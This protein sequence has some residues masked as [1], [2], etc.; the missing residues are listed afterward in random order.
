MSE[1]TGSSPVA[2]VTGGAGFIGFHLCRALLGA[3]WH[4]RVLDNLSTG[5]FS[6]LEGLPLEFVEGDIRDQGAVRGALQGVNAVLHQAALVSVVESVKDPEAAHAINVE[7]TR[8]VFSEALAAGATRATFASSAAV[9]GDAAESP[10]HEGLPVVPLSPYGVGK[11][12]GE[13]IAAEMTAAGL[14][15][16]P[17]RYFNIYGPGQDPRGPYA[18][19]I[20]K[21]TAQLRAGARLTLFGD[22]E[23]TR[24]FCFVGDVVR[25]NLLALS[26]GD[27]RVAGRP[28]NI[29]TGVPVSVWTLIET[30]G[31]LLG[32]TPEVDQVPPREGDIRHSV[33]EVSLARAQLGFRASVDLKH[34]LEALLLAE[35]VACV[36]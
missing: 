7:G 28:M 17:L 16:F 25:A 29:G 10:Q 27:I 31:E 4:V 15:V 8:M 22:G 34:G 20:A 12:A 3:G 33:A 5:T 1:A 14:A 26:S 36:P 11:A 6:R 2:L 32:V 30:L 35:E 24:D 18:A 23:Q 9:Y 21:F 13:A 19:V